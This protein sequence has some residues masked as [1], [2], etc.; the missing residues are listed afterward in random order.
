MSRTGCCY[1]NE[2]AER[3]FWSLKFGWTGSESSKNLD[4]AKISA[5]K[6][7]ETSNNPVRLHQTLDYQTPDPFE[8]KQTKP[9]VE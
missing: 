2:D 5:F 9:L 1:D 7:I 6:H 8:R 3:L 4:A